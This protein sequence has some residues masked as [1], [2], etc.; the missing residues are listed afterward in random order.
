MNLR[1]GISNYFGFVSVLFFSACAFGMQGVTDDEIVIGGAHDLSGPFSSFSVPAV[2]A[3]QLY[4]KQVN[5][6]GGIHGRKIRYLVEDHGYQVPK[7]VQVV[8][9]LVNRDKVFAMLM[10]LGTSHNLAAFRI[11]DKKGIP[12][13]APLSGARQMLQDPYEHKYAFM[14][15]YFDQMRV[16]VGYLAREYE[17]SKA[18]AMYIPSDYGKDVLQGAQ[19]G[20]K[21]SNIEWVTETTH[22]AD[23]TDYAGALT[24]LKQ[25]QCNLVSLALSV[26][27]TISVLSTAKKLGWDT[28]RFIGSSASFHSAIAKVPGG[29]TDDFWVAAGWEDLEVRIAQ[30]QVKAW[31]ESFQGVGNESLPG[32][33]ALLGRTAAEIF[34]RGLRHAGPNLNLD[35]F[36]TGME[37]VSFKDPISGGV[38]KL[39]AGDH[40]AMEEVIISRIVK[41]SWKTV[42]R[43]L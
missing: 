1:L 22:K 11:L 6:S 21:E 33:G 25:A 4:F 8:N 10:M 30:P 17:A 15:S 29:V 7:A 35:T 9:K 27:G 13:V 39:G 24:K 43:G 3:A 5:A 40:Q 36:R 28:V 38:I 42:A 37:L 16:G 2:K 14:S 32:S 12:N 19:Q 31:I 26:R 41:G 23:E 20:A 34:V 18:C